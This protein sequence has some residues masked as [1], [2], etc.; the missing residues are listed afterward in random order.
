MAAT[1]IEIQG[2]LQ[3]DGTL[4]LDQKPNLPPGRVKVTM[5][6][7]PDLQKTEIWEFLERIHAEQRA[8]GFVPRSVEEIDAEIADGRD[9]D[10]RSRLIEQIQEECR[11]QREGPQRSEGP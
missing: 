2:T 3:E 6:V 9:D 8:R 11:R 7:I 10:E 5:Q 4:L 1:A